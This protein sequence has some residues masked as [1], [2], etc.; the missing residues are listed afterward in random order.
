MKALLCAVA[1]VFLANCCFG[2]KVPNIYQIRADTV[3]IYNTCDTAE[4]VLENR[5][6]DTLGFLFNKGKG[7]T[8][9]R[10]L[11]LERIGASQL[12]IKGQ[13]TIDLN[14]YSFGD[15]R[16]DLLSTN[17]VT[18]PSGDSLL[19]AQWPLRKVVGYDAYNSPDMPALSRQAIQGMGTNTYYNGL[20]V[21]DGDSGFDFAVNW[22]GELS[23]PNGAFLRT[24]DDTKT[25]WSKWRELLFKDYADTT[26]APRNSETLQSVMARGNT[27]GYNIVFGGNPASSPGLYWGY[28]TDAWKIFVES[29]QDTPAGDMIFESIDNQQE[30]WVFRTNTPTGTAPNPILNIQPEGTFTY[31]G[32]NI[33]HAGNHV[34]GSAFTP[35]LTGANV[36]SSITTNAS[37]HVTALTTRTLTSTDIG[38]APLTGSGNYIQNQN[39]SAQSANMWINGAVSAPVFSSNQTT[40]VVNILGGLSGGNQ[41]GRIDL[42]GGTNASVPGVIL[43]RT[44]KGTGTQPERMRIKDNGYMFFNSP[45]SLYPY[46]FGD[47]D[48]GGYQLNLFPSTAN[49]V[50]SLIATTGTNSIGHLHFSGYPTTITG[51]VGY[52][53]V[54]TSAASITLDTTQRT[55]LVNT[56]GTATVTLPAAINNSGREYTI[57]K[58]SAAGNNVTINVSGGGNIDGSTSFILQ[59]QYAAITVQSD[60]SQWRIIGS[61]SGGKTTL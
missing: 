26:Y 51:G 4:F 29:P 33:L 37:G 44:G 54:S 39:T 22:D 2:Q 57:K 27:T 1:F 56:T 10:R 31:L 15:T 24:K 6:K 11:G 48:Q 40:G 25:A 47:P 16:Y 43:F 53:I 49:K 50:V 20:V 61:W 41:G 58:I 7:R 5:T 12:A 45:G 59:T 8:E 23:G 28:N 21:R 38:A 14:F 9:F 34:A 30:G 52:S 55:L 46:T 60:G 36:L 42:Y 18:I 19:F 35:T 17:F 3:R 32:N 13:D